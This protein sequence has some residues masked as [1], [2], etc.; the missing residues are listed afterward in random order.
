MIGGLH[1]EMTAKHV[2]VCDKLRIKIVEISV[3]SVLVI[4]CQTRS[5]ALAVR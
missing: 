2:A 3:Y 4:A 5:M 1:Q